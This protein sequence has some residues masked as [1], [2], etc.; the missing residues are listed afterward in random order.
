MADGEK[1]V[2]EA[3]WK[4]VLPGGYMRENVTQKSESGSKV[5]ERE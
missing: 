5:E 2:V 4:I 3:E 1:D